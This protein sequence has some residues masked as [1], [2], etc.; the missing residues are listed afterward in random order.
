[1]RFLDDRCAGAT[2]QRCQLA[3]I[4]ALKTFDPPLEALEGK[5][6][7]GWQRH[8]KYLAMVADGL[9]LVLNL[10]R[11]GWITWWDTPPRGTVRLGGRGP[12]G[13]RVSLDGGRGRMVGA[14]T[15]VIL[16]ALVQNILILSQIQTFWIDAANGLVILIALGLARLIGSERS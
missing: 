12:L 7:K 14:L 15:G 13:L 3:S 4:S 16:L 5:P 10:A 1:M 6:V 2:V 11:G 8:G 9:W